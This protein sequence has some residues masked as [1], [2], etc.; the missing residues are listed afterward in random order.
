MVIVNLITGLRYAVIT[1]V[2]INTFG[3]AEVEIQDLF[4]RFQPSSITTFHE[5]GQ[6]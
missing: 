1:F 5:V 6:L 3:S 2:V 4:L